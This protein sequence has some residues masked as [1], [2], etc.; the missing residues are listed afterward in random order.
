MK[1]AKYY[2]YRNLH[3]PGFFSIKHKGIVIG[4]LNKFVCDD[5]SFIVS[6]QGFDKVKI[7][8][9]RNVHAYAVVDKMPTHNEMADEFSDHERIS[10]YPHGDTPYFQLVRSKIN[11]THSKRAAFC[12][13]KIYNLG[14]TE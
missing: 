7:T 5:V 10:Y 1:A 12:D 6:K 13:G 4:H 3:M 11:V 2:V 9:H 14:V 8:K